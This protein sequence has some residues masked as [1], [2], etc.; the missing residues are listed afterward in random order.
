VA[1]SL[2]AVRDSKNQAGPVLKFDQ[3]QLAAFLSGAK[4]GRFDS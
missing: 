3:D 4:S 2:D 1:N